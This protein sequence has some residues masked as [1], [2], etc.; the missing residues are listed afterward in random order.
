MSRG[1]AASL[2]QALS[3]KSW[4]RAGSLAE[5]FIAG[6]PLDAQGWVSLAEARIGAGSRG[7]A[8]AALARGR[9]LDPEG[10]WFDPLSEQAERLPAA[11]KLTDSTARLLRVRPVTVCAAILAKNEER[12]IARCIDS[13]QGA[14]DEIIVM[15]TGSTDR[16]LDIVAS[17]PDVKLLKTT[18]DDSFAAAR[19]ETIPHIRSD[20]VLWID[21]DEWL[22]PEDRTAIRE[23]AGLFDPLPIPSVLQIWHLHVVGSEIAHDFSQSRMF[24]LRR[25]L[26]FFGR[27]HN[28]VAAEDGVYGNAPLLRRKVGI[29]LYHDGYDPAVMKSKRKTDRAER[30]L[31]LSRAESP[32]DPAWPYFLGRERFGQG[33]YADAESSFEEALRLAAR[34][35][36]FGRTL[37]LRLWL[38][39][40]AVADRRWDVARSRCEAI[41]KETPDFPDA[42]YFLAQA[43]IAQAKEKFR[44]AEESAILAAES[45]K[46]YRGTVAADRS[47]REWRAPVLLADLAVHRGKLAEA[48]AIY[49]AY[50]R[51]AGPHADAIR[52]K[53]AF[54]ERQRKKLEQ[55]GLPPKR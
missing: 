49:R 31:R 10:L 25:G 20:W 22:H 38:V 54:I 43:L 12:C 29:R 30:L 4:E 33:S 48:R 2:R 13:L 40:C 47:I 1:D 6:R 50:V 9:L 23:A 55:A 15:D 35:P 32:D 28:Q 18:W 11:A 39:K 34:Q 16:T 51:K 42:H 37:E 52:R 45:A 3:S 26:R 41:L 44:E 27:I 17:Y 36:R 19:N 21:A 14:V 53:L 8:E 46:T 7:D 24:P 5:A